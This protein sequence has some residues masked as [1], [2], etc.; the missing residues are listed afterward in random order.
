MAK[1]LETNNYEK[2][3]LSPFNRDLGKIMR[4]KETFLKFGWINCYPCGVVRLPNGK[5][6]IRFGHHRFKVAVMLGMTI[7][8]VEIDPEIDVAMVELANRPWEL[9]DWLMSYVRGGKEN[10]DEVLRYHEETG[11]GLRACLSMLAGESAASGNK[12]EQF[13]RG[14]Y[15][16]KE[17]ENMEVV[18]GLVECLKKN[19]ISWATT[20][21][22]V[23]ALSKVALVSKEDGFDPEILKRK[24][25]K[26]SAFWEKRPNMKG[27]VNLIEEIYNRQSQNKVPLG[28]LADEAARKRNVSKK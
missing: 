22:L 16:I 6:E 10:Y 4:F 11:I 21:P 24:I 12:V 1:I 27:Y 8:Y 5:L 26:F 14:I 13:K 17:N 28:F 23:N 20:T 15:E 7:K 19:G 18:R 9:K 25:A 2:F 3:V